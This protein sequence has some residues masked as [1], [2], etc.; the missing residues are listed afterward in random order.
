[1]IYHRLI[2]KI[3]LILFCLNF[4]EALDFSKCQ[5]Y[6]LQASKEFVLNNGNMIRAYHIGEGRYLAF[7]KEDIEDERLKKF[8]KLLGLALFADS[9]IEKRYDLV[10]IKKE[11]PAVALNGA[12]STKGV[13]KQA[14]KSLKDL[15]VFSSP[16]PQNAMISD[17]C[18]QMY[19]ISV[20]GNRFIDKQYIERFLNEKSAQISHTSLGIILTNDNIIKDINPFVSSTLR[21]GD[22]IISLNNKPISSKEEFIN[23]EANLAPNKIATISAKRGK[24]EIIVALMPFLRIVDFDKLESYMAFFGLDL[25]P[26]LVILNSPSFGGFKQGDKFLRLNQIKI[27]NINELNMAIR[28]VL[29][30]NENMSFLINRENFELFITLKEQEE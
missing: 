5:E 7:S 19:G 25:S 14:Q 8:D 15:A 21:I 10:K 2:N 1:M 11:I 13:I 26:D 4:L 9:N 16:M 28:A 3:L 24:N 17:I 12:S 6:Q 22:K 20:G 18:Y 23:L 29:K 30:Q 27:S